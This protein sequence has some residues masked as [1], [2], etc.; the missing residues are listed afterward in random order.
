MVP[1]PMMMSMTMMMMIDKMVGC[2]RLPFKHY[3][4]KS[5]EIEIEIETEI[6]FKHGNLFNRILHIYVLYPI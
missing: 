2:S 5:V 3:E 4:N 1:S 6:T